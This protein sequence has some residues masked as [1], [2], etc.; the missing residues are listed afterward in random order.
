M[1][2]APQPPG[3]GEKKAQLER[4][5]QLFDSVSREKQMLSGD[6][7]KL[8]QRQERMTKLYPAGHEVPKNVGKPFQQVTKPDEK[9]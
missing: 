2:H 7:E 9:R 5:K 6:P 8:R 1:E 4:A 3:N